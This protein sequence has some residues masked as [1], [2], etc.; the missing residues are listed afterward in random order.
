[1]K[2]K[3]TAFRMSDKTFEI[4]Y[5]FGLFEKKREIDSQKT[6]DN[7]LKLRNNPPTDLTEPISEVT[8]I[9]NEDKSFKVFA[10]IKDDF[11]GAIDAESVVI[12]IGASIEF[13]D[14]SI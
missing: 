11:D 14:N 1:M 5:R 6:I 3:L 8:I 7:I 10:T 13:K 12:L 9:H 4:E 2:G